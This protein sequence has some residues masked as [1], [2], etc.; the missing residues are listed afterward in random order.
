MIEVMIE[1]SKAQLYAIVDEKLKISS[2]TICITGASASGKTTLSRELQNKYTESVHIQQ[3]MWYHDINKIERDKEGY[4]DM[5]SEKAFHMDE[6]LDAL[7]DYYRYGVIYEPCYDFAINQRTGCSNRKARSKLT[8][9]DGLHS[10]LCMNSIQLD[11]RILLDKQIMFVFMDTDIETCSRRRAE[12]DAKFMQQDG[13]GY[14]SAYQNIVWFYKNVVH[15]HYE[16]ILHQQKLTC[17]MKYNSDSF[18]V[19]L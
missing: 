19:V 9:I 1:L 15:R 2:V 18:A 11:K 5:E 12:R 8:I 13:I 4:Y 14:D 17:E 6:F 3:D 16:K 7:R 10:A